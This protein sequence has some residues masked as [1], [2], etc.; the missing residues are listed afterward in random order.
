M[1]WSWNSWDE[2]SVL[3]W[4]LE[5]PIQDIAISPDGTDVVVIVAGKILRIPITRPVF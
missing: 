3:P 5:L 4:D 1:F 2:N